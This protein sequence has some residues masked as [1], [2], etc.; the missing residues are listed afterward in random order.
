MENRRICFRILRHGKH[1]LHFGFNLL[2]P[3]LTGKL[4]VTCS[5]LKENLVCFKELNTNKHND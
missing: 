2:L 5:L 1:K 3:F 4:R